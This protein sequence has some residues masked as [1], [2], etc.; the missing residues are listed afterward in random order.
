MMFVLRMAWREV[1]S[2]GPRLLFFFLCVA[3]GVAAIVALRSVVQEVRATLIREARDLVGA[4]LIVQS[5]RQWPAD[6][7]ARLVEYLGKPPAQERMEVI[8]TST[9]AA[10]GERVQLVELRGVADG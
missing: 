7:Q 1:R 5:S 6:V 8:E 3:L 2:S 10:A 9:M 4:D